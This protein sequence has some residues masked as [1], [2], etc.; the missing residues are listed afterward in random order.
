MRTA[1]GV[2]TTWK[3]RHCSIFSVPMVRCISGTSSKE[4]WSQDSGL[5]KSRFQ[6]QDRICSRTLN[7][8]KSSYSVRVLSEA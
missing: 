7:P 5:E 3:V 8:E 4:D 6:T 2:S 1:A